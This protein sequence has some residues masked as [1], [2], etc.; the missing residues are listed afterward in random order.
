M[1]LEKEK[2]AEK[3]KAQEDVNKDI[4]MKM[5]AQASAP[6]AAGGDGVSLEMTRPCRR[7]YVGNLP[8]AGELPAG[9]A[10]NEHVL[11]QFFTECCRGLGIKTKNPVMS[12]WLNSD[13]TFGFVEFRAIQDCTLSLSLFQGL[14]LGGR[15][16]KFGRPV[17]Y[18]PPPLHLANYVVPL[19]GN[20]GEEKEVVVEEGTPAAMLAKIQRQQSTNLTAAAT[21]LITGKTIMGSEEKET[22]KIL[23]I[24]NLVTKEYFLDEAAFEDVVDDIRVECYNLS[25]GTLEDVLVPTP[26]GETGDKGIGRVFLS[27]ESEAGAARVLVKVN[28]RQFDGRKVKAQYFPVAHWE[29]RELDAVLGGGEENGEAEE[30]AEKEEIIAADGT[31]SEKPAEESTTTNGAPEPQPPTEPGTPGPGSNSVPDLPPGI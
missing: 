20:Q 17:D 14:Q 16:L 23:L 29:N 28:N 1:A 4:K 9:M 24:E 6:S 18:K 25:L 12:S 26:N 19:I 8:S 2:I 13:C 7:L 15:T 5:T 27:F 31:A 10:L 21:G 3:K 22:S 11:S 30:T